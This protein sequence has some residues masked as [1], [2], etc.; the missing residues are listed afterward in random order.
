MILLHWEVESCDN[1]LRRQESGFGFWLSTS[2][3][4]WVNYLTSLSFSFLSYRIAVRTK[5]KWIH[6]K[7]LEKCLVHSGVSSTTIA[8]QYYVL[9]FSFCWLKNL[10]IIHLFLTRKN[11]DFVYFYTFLIP[12]PIFCLYHYFSSFISSIRKLCTCKHFIYIFICYTLNWSYYFFTPSFVNN[13]SLQS[14]GS[15]VLE[16]YFNFYIH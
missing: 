7:Q 1:G 4:V 12:F 6:T 15:Q 8:N 2:G 14:F 5:S 3:V 9:L 13:F 10:Y 16:T 11:K